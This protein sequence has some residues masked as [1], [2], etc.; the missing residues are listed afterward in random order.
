MHG[1]LPPPNPATSILEPTSDNQGTENPHEPTTQ[2]GREPKVISTADREALLLFNEA[3]LASKTVDQHKKA[4]KS[5]MD[6]LAHRAALGHPVVQD[7]LMCSLAQRDQQ[8]LVSLWIIWMTTIKNIPKQRVLTLRSHLRSNWTSVNLPP[9]GAMGQ[10]ITKALQ[11][12]PEEARLTAHQQRNKQKLPM[13]PEVLMGLF[14]DSFAKFSQQGQLL[15]TAG[16]L[17]SMGAMLACMLGLESAQRGGNWIQA[18]GT[19]SQPVQTRDMRFQVAV[20]E[21]ASSSSTSEPKLII[22]QFTGEA[23]RAALAGIGANTVDTSGVARV[24]EV[25]IDI[26]ATKQGEP[27]LDQKIGRRTEEEAVILE[28]I[29][30]WL[31]L[32]GTKN[33][34]PFLTRYATTTV[35][36]RELSRRLITDSDRTKK[37][38]ESARRAGLNPSHFSSTSL[39]K[40]GI[41]L[42]SDALGQEMAASRSG[43][44]SRSGVMSKHYDYSSNG[45]RGESMGPAALSKSSSFGVE[46]LKK[47]IPS[48]ESGGQG[49][50]EE[51]KGKNDKT[52]RKGSRRRKV[53]PSKEYEGITNGA[54]RR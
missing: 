7:P 4:W 35:A 25:R 33:S 14:H 38:K 5:W 42:V 30:T 51:A 2:E 19:K 22:Q 15:P 40:G 28:A 54:S 47:L 36:K 11:P 37:V 10:R 6:F 52:K 31:L 26:I 1:H 3:G 48:G 21:A 32:S 17:D 12:S 29:T 41:T 46:Q 39:R 8:D 50:W 24:Q 34:D 53:T 23:A 44:S 49:S 18:R 27:V 20:G 43:H 13:L 45:G 16:E 9:P